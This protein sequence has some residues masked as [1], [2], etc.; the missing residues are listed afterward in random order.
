MGL[1]KRID[2]AQGRLQVEG[3]TAKG[4]R[5]VSTWVQRAQEGAAIGQPV[6]NGKGLPI[7]ATGGTR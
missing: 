6:I 4:E 5:V 7:R 2:K 3:V 1:Q